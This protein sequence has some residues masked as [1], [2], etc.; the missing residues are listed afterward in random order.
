MPPN[1]ALQRTRGSIPKSVLYA[2]DWVSDVA[3]QIYPKKA[4][5]GVDGKYAT[6][7]TDYWKYC[8]NAARTFFWDLS[9]AGD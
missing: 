9:L 5:S 6:S 7:M 8:R 1:K 3:L 2:D 4:A